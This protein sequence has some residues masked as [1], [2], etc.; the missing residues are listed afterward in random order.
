MFGLFKKKKAAQSSIAACYVQQREA[1]KARRIADVLRLYGT[2]AEENE[3]WDRLRILLGPHAEQFLR[4]PL[5]HRFAEV[6]NALPALP[7][8]REKV[9]R[10]C[11]YTNIAGGFARGIGETNKSEELFKVWEQCCQQRLIGRH[12]FQLVDSVDLRFGGELVHRL[13]QYL[14]GKAK[15][16]GIDLTYRDPD[17]FMEA[18]HQLPVERRRLLVGADWNEFVQSLS[19]DLAEILVVEMRKSIVNL[20]TQQF[21]AIDFEKDVGT[22][23]LQ[24][25]L[26]HLRILGATIEAPILKQRLLALLRL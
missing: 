16:M 17:E 18:V 8:D 15:G 6:L 22:S 9:E 7:V 26:K 2:E 11:H 20:K 10:I 19:V 24:E 3:A 25:R 14:D 12:L 1:S 23:S 13:V 21:S 5:S 4:I